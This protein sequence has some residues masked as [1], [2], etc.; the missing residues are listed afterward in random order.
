[1]LKEQGMDYKK[2]LCSY[3]LKCDNCN[4]QDS[5]QEVKQYQ[6]IISNKKDIGVCVKGDIHCDYFLRR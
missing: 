4:K 2:I 1:M 5:M 3:C 6:P